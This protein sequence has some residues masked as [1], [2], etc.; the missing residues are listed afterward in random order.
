MFDFFDRF[1][2]FIVVSELVAVSLFFLMLNKFLLVARRED[3]GK[4]VGSCRREKIKFVQ[5]TA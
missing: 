3:L 5:L 4:G 2:D 1:P